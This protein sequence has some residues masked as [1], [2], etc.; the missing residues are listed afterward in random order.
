MGLPPTVDCSVPLPSVRPSVCTCVCL[1]MKCLRLLY[2]LLIGGPI[3]N[4]ARRV[5]RAS[6]V[7]AFDDASLVQS[8]ALKSCRSAHLRDQHERTH[9]RPCAHAHLKGG[10]QRIKS[11]SSS[12]SS[13]SSLGRHASNATPRP[14]VRPSVGGTCV[15]VMTHTT[16]LA[17]TQVRSSSIF[18]GS[19]LV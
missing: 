14:S 17:R 8:G 1:C 7:R 9:K 12:S 3:T 4:V 19:G 2:R 5:E 15:F 10:G 16:N 11:D 18:V 6:E 13:S